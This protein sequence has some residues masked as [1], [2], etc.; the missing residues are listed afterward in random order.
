MKR[1]LKNISAIQRP[2]TAVRQNRKLEDR[3]RWEEKG[4]GTEEEWRQRRTWPRRDRKAE[5]VRNCAYEK[6]I[7]I[8]FWVTA[9]GGRKRWR[10]GAGREEGLWLRSTVQ[11][12]VCATWPCCLCGVSVRSVPRW[13][14]M[15]AH[16]PQQQWNT[17]SRV[18]CALQL[19]KY[20][21][22]MMIKNKL[23]R[24]GTKH[25]PPHDSRLRPFYTFDTSTHQVFFFFVCLF[26]FVVF[27]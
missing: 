17:C 26:D 25:Q 11:C 27:K 1:N 18:L 6:F 5:R 9:E 8:M 21:T 16:V 10:R 12:L 4:W 24:F 19:Y 3:G 2:T 20:W 23:I 13:W 22:K 7:N 15:E 14:R